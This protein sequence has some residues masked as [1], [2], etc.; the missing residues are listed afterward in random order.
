MSHRRFGLRLR[1]FATLTGAALLCAAILAVAMLLRA[2]DEI[3][4]R[5]VATARQDLRTAAESI[6]ARCGADSTCAGE[7]A[8]AVGLAWDP[9]A[10]C[11]PV[12]VSG[13]A[14]VLCERIAGAAVHRRL[15]LSA[16]STQAQELVAPVLAFVLGGMVLAV[17][18]VF[19][20][21]DRQLVA[22]LARI[23]AALDGVSEFSSD[24]PLL[25]E[26]GDLLGRLAPAVN[27]LDARL[28]EERARVKTQI[29]ELRASNEQLRAAREEVARSERLASVGRLA[30]GV[31]HEVG[32][33]MTAVIGY[34]DLLRERLEQGKGAEEY[35]ERIAR[36]MGR[37]DRILRDLLNL[38]RGPGEV[39]PVDL[40]AA[41]ENARGLVEAQP[42]WNGCAVRV[43]VPGD[44]PRARAENHY[45]VQVL[46]NLLVNAAKAGARTVEMLG[47][48]VDGAPV[49]R[50]IDDGRGLPADAA[51][52]LFEPFFTT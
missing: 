2:R 31:A 18:L 50:V 47:E 14:I 49:L 48:V 25:P 9:G 40:R 1:L 6:A 36:E 27:R 39:Q 32:N 42:S 51:T 52:R 46:L 44:L 43:R 17:A 23:D 3:A 34:V 20:L 11:P 4:Q 38:A 24:E 7:S 35:V 15:D 22:P 37:I 19:W 13:H 21:L 33:P 29:G 16:A 28:R 8:G 12:H 10:T 41:A 30:A 45:V 5:H 26:G